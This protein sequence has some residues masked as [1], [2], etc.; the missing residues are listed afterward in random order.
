MGISLPFFIACER[1]G[2]RYVIRLRHERGVL[3]HEDGSRISFA[4]AFAGATAVAKGLGDGRPYASSSDS[5]QMR[6]VLGPRPKQ[7]RRRR[8]A[9]DYQ[10]QRAM[11]P[12]LLATNLENEPA[13]SIVRIAGRRSS[14]ARLGEVPSCQLTAPAHAV[15]V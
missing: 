1:L 2:M 14:G 3:E 15:G 5:R 8:S 13:Q 10:R 11:E 6:I 7:R 9:V 4:Q 12:W